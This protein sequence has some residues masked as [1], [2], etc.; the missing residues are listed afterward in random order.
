MIR[1]CDV[2]FSIIFI[3]ILS[4]LF[5]VVIIILSV[6][7]ERKIFFTQT[8]MGKD[9]K[10]FSLL[11]FVTMLQNSPHIGTGNITIENDPR[12]LP[13]GKFLR[14]SKINE[15]PQLC[16]ILIGDMSFIGPRPLT[17][18]RFEIYNVNQQEIISK[19]KPGLSGIGSIIFRDEEKILNNELN[20][21][22]VYDNII[23][24]YKGELEIWYAKKNSLLYYFILIFLTVIVVLKIPL[25]KRINNFLDL[26]KKPSEL[27]N[28]MER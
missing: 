8:R 2:L 27:N 5:F 25:S 15:L 12:V 21:N 20:A 1:L 4:P 14:A 11:K 18:D 19:L 17:P 22:E 7:G 23:A 3:V 28:L 9:M 24:P 26:P 10:T 16:N 13:L 6:T